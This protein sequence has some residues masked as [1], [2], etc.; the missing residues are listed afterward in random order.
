MNFIFYPCA[1]GQMKSGVKRTGEILK[2]YL[3]SKN[4][5]NIQVSKNNMY[6]NLANL[7]KVNR[8]I[9][10]TRVNIGGDHS[11]AI[12]T[13]A[14]SLNKYYNLKMIWIDAHPDI[15]TTYSSTSNNYHGMPLGFLTG[16]DYDPYFSFI[17]NN[18]NFNNIMYIG[19]RDIDN[20]EKKVIE[21]TNIKC[22]FSDEIN[23]NTEHALLKINQFINNDSFH[24]SFD[25]DSMDPS[26]IFS[27]GTP[28]KNG[29]YLSPMEKILSNLIK[30][31][32]MINMDITEMN[33]DI[34][35]IDQKEKSLKSLLYLINSL[36]I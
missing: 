27:T 24:L 18:L 28:V 2:P 9:R 25:V 12:A 16:L 15:N 31:P 14:F 1:L 26:V 5:Y 6:K 33:L 19:L 32:N 22:I 30:N 11:M 21:N 34:G 10:G 4:I 35:S 13:G 8:R 3:N 20:F 23:N 36:T 29:I 17:K 7:Y